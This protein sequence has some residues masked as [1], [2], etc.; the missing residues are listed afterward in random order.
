MDVFLKNAINGSKKEKIFMVI[1]KY[2][3]YFLDNRTRKIRK[4]R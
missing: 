4:Y 3:G 1:N 2:N